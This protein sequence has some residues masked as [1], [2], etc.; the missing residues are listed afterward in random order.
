M[1]FPPGALGAQ[2]DPSG[3]LGNRQNRRGMSKMARAIGGGAR[4][5]GQ[6]GGTGRREIEWHSRPA[7]PSGVLSL[8]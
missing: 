7:Q 8:D 2:A 5:P 6:S 3:D 4:T 1:G